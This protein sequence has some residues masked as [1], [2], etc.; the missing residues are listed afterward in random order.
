MLNTREEPIVEIHD[1]KDLYH[2]DEEIGSVIF[3]LDDTLYS[4][5]DYVR[6]VSE[7]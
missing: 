2:L 4:E 3:D 5:K 1:F 6:A 7:W